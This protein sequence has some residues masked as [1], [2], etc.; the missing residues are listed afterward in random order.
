VEKSVN[1]VTGRHMT[2][3]G[4]SE[5]SSTCNGGQSINFSLCCDR[6]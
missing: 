4:E 6:L 3:S 1:I 2:T 5:H